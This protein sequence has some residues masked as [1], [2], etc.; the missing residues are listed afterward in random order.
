MRIALADPRLAFWGPQAVDQ[1]S[2]ALRLERF[3]SEVARALAGQI[4]PLANLRSSAGCAVVVASDSPRIRLH[5][6]RLRHHQ[7]VP[8]GIA[9]E[10]EDD[11]G[12]RVANS[13]DLREN[14]G[15]CMVELATGLTPGRVRPLW[16]WLPHIATCAV[17]GL[18]VD[19]GATLGPVAL[20]TPRWL[21]IG[22]SLTQGFTVQSPV[23]GWVHRLMRR[24]NLPVWN[25]GVGG[26]RIETQAF[27][28]ALLSRTWDLVTIALGSNHAW[29]ESE[30][31][32]A[33]GAAERLLEV[34][35]RG[36]PDGAHRRVVWCLPPWKPCEEGKGPPDFAGM[37]LDRA[38]G[39]RVGRVRE[40]LRARLK[41]EPGL[42]LAE[43][44][45]PHDA[46]LY[47]DG[48]H[49]TA[50]GAACYA[51]ALDRVLGHEEEFGTNKVFPSVS[52]L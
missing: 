8:Q 24:R 44:L 3:P 49:P 42:T 32:T 9:L 47:P 26:L 21:A 14:E 4:G 30:V 43:D 41:Y 31:T 48:L 1:Q 39:E 25:L 28:W 46:R 29:R 15:D 33:V 34:V 38:A 11:A 17:A 23:Q 18:D 20:P 22:D 12:W 45:L 40:A 36:G 2:G 16:L 6:E 50:Y 13:L 37:P 19:E 5:L 10:V 52:S 27:A 7:P 51:T 35:R